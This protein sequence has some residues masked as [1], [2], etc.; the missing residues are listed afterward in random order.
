MDC[1]DSLVY[2]RYS[3]RCDYN[4]DPLYSGCESNPCKNNG[5]CVD[6]TT[7]SYKCECQHGYTGL[8]CENAPDYCVSNPCGSNGV[9][10]LLPFN[11]PFPFYCTCF[12]EQTFGLDCSQNNN[13]RNPCSSDTEYP[14]DFYATKLNPTMFV[15][16]DGKNL[17]LKSCASPLVYSVVDKRCEWKDDVEKRNYKPLY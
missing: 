6:V 14:T 16:C 1:P 3:D 2:N 12:N 15:H 10:H 7:L 4:A 11:S 8:V 17:N 5:K 9:C 13:E